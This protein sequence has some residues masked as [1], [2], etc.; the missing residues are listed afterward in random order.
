MI[1]HKGEILF[2]QGDHGPLYRINSGM[3]KIVRIH[4]DGSQ[5]LMNII[6]PGEVIPHHSLVS[7]N[8]N[9]GTAIALMPTEVEVIQAHDWYTKLQENP[10]HYREIALLL[11]DK[12]M[13]LQQR[14][15]QLSQVTPM[16]KL[17]KL[18]AWAHQF[19]AP[20]TLIDIL[21]QDEIGQLIGL[22][23]E[24]VNRLLRAQAHAT[25]DH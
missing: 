6:T 14:I 7:P 25:T 12:L 23:R 19:I 22:R 20:N 21:T 2:R 8:I 17:E 16:Q 10:M 13:M 3:L 1:L 9:H 18:Q 15:D 24:T 11:Q 5:I 4:E